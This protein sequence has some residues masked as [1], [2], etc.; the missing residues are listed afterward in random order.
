MLTFEGCLTEVSTN[1]G[2]TILHLI[3][4]KVCLPLSVMTFEGKTRHVC[5]MPCPCQGHQ[6]PQNQKSQ[7]GQC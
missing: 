5:E 1:T 7:D 3:F 2:L 4:V 6:G